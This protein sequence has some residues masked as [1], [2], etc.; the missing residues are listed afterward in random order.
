MKYNAKY[1]RWFSK[2]G[3]VYRYDK[4]ADKLV[5]CNLYSM[6]KGYLG[7][8]TRLNGHSTCIR[9]HKAVWETFNG[10]IP[11]GYEI[12]HINTDRTDN[13]LDNLRCVTH[14]ENIN[15]PLTLI[16]MRN[17]KSRC[18][19]YSGNRKCVTEFGIKFLNKFGSSKD[20]PRL[21]N[22]EYNFYRRHGYCRW[23]VE[24]V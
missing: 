13:R 1:N 17:P 9:V 2:E 18:A 6:I 8:G 11:A 3:L 19:G 7:F 10:E 16:K 15:N 22:M 20:N 4:K 24:N 5:L 14:K 12:D 23:E 21:Y